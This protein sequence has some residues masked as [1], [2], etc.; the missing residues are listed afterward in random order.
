M[1]DLAAIAAPEWVETAGL[2]RL[3]FGCCALSP[4]DFD[5]HA[6]TLFG[7]VAGVGQE[8]AARDATPADLE[9][10]QILACLTVRQ[11]RKPGEDPQPLR[12]VLAETDED[13]AA[14]RLWVGRLPVEDVGHIAGAGIRRY[15][16]AAARAARFRRGSEAASHDG[17]DG[18]AV[19]DDPGPVAVQAAG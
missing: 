18:E 16:E 13:T 12:L 8:T 19:R 14:G 5:R 15:V 2:G 4:A 6:G 11:V 1:I 9:H 7:L 17:R 3:D 10:I